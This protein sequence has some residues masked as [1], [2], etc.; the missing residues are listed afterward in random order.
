MS[1]IT[2]SSLR[3][4]LLLTLVVACGSADTR[5]LAES[6]KL[7]AAGG[8]PHDYFGYAVSTDGTHAIVG[9]YGDDD[10]GQNAGA[11]YIFSTRNKKWT[12]E[13]KLIPLQARPNEQIGIAVDISGDFAWVGSRGDIE[14]GSKTG[15][16][17]VYRKLDEGWVQ[18]S[19]FRSHEFRADDLY[20]LSIAVDGD[21]AVVGAHRD[22]K[23]G[24]D[25]GS[26]YVY[27]L[28][29]DVWTFSE[30]LYATHGKA[31][32]YFGFDVDIDRSQ[33]IVGAF[34][35][36]EKGNR[37]GAAYTF[38]RIQN[39]WRQDMK[40]TAPD[41]GKHALFGHSVALSGKHAIVGAHGSWTH[42][43]FSGA[44]YVYERTQRGWKFVQ[45]VKAPDNRANKYF[46][47]SVDISPKRILVGARGDSHDSIIQSGAAY[48]FTRSGS[49]FGS[50]IKLVA[51]LAEEL[52]FLGRS[53]SVCD[54][55]GL[56]GTHG[57]DDRGSLSGSVYTF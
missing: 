51:Q 1:R 37:A 36:D 4:L 32:D 22:P 3:S 34:G 12:E 49:K 57:D 45:Q 30:R 24:R 48:L 50:P 42:G 5:P 47:F 19:T 38:R 15:A 55:F 11:A 7:R 17:Y 21:W 27:H 20:G 2:G 33:I 8:E 14:S 6:D 10:R 25:A 56:A 40:L 16:A 18:I 53:V 54:G 28:E 31:A 13:A 43:R 9:A 46:G 35:D 29:N 44:A 39:S 23:N 52:D 41:G 26:V